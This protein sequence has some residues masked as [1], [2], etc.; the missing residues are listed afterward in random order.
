[1]MKREVDT[2]HKTRPRVFEAR[3][4]ATEAFQLS[5]QALQRVAFPVQFAIVLPWF[6][7]IRFGWHHRDHVHF[8]TSCRVSSLS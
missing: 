5:A 3:E 7:P 2:D 6:A 4:D 8:S 1:M